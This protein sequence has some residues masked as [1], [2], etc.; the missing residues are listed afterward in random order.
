[1]M[2]KD[3]FSQQAIDYTQYRPYYPQALFAYL[4]TLAKTHQCAW[5][6][7]TGNGQAAKGLVPYFKKII[8]TDASERQ[9]AYVFQHP[10]VSYKVELAEQ[11]TIRTHSVD[12]VVVA[13]A[14]HWFDFEAFYAEIKRVLKP[15]GI[16]ALW[17]YR[18]LH[19]TPEIDHLVEH[20]YTDVLGPFWPAERRFVDAGYQ[21]LPFPFQEITPPLFE[22]QAT[23]SL[24]HLIGYLHTWS[25]VQKFKEQRKR[26]PVIDIIAD[27]RQAWGIPATEKNVY[28][29]ISLRIGRLQ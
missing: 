7:A 19:I 16:I 23:W 3:Y 17:C 2:F 15:Q 8:A 22:M 20:F 26:D 10:Q 18:L 25:A 1:M 9:I 29:P 28:W 4:A 5:D 14:A 21:T 6:C 12:L 27:L 13:Q 11:T 24:E